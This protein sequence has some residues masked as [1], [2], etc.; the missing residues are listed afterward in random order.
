MSRAGTFHSYVTWGLFDE[1]ML[2]PTAPTI[3]STDHE[4]GT[5]VTIALSGYDA[6]TTNELFISQD[7]ITWTSYGSSWTADEMELALDNG[8]YWGYVRSTDTG[9]C[10]NSQVIRVTATNPGE[11]ADDNINTAV[12]V[13]KA[14]A[15]YWPPE[16]NY[17][18]YGKPV[19]NEPVEIS[20]YW[21]NRQ[22]EFLDESGDKQK[23]KAVVIVD[24]DLLITGILMLGELTDVTDFTDPKNNTNAWEIRGW[25]KTPNFKGN[26]YLRQAYL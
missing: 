4:D 23:S 20:C 2:I 26:K 16:T 22:E 7:G 18:Q 12:K 3:T 6:G 17:D 5:G 25:G 1:S 19:P 21:D 11:A 14:T 15:V 24:R 10:S 13:M 8:V 9:T